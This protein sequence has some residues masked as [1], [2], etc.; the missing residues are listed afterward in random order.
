MPKFL[1]MAHA[2]GAGGMVVLA[3]V[4]RRLWRGRRELGML[5]DCV[6]RIIVFQMVKPGWVMSN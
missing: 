2:D 6:G 3:T 1:V 5:R 4:D